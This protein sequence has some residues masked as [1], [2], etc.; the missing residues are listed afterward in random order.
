MTD[1]EK[2]VETGA[3][4]PVDEAPRSY[5]DF[6]VRAF[7]EPRAGRLSAWTRRPLPSDASANVSVI[8]G[9]SAAAA[10]MTSAATRSS[11]SLNDA[12]KRAAKARPV[13]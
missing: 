1:E 11:G 5:T 9:R 10:T 3:E 8:A 2:V 6:A 7:E 12:D 13:V 4:A